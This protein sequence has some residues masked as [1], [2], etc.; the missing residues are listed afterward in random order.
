MKN[1]LPVTALLS[2]LCTIAHAQK[3]VYGNEWINLQQAYYKIPIAQKGLYRLTYVDLQRAGLPLT[4]LDPQK[5]QLFHRGTEQ[6]IW[7][8]G[9]AD[10]KFD[11]TDYIEFLGRGNDGVQDSTLYRPASAQPNPYYSLYSDSTAFFL[12]IRSDT[13]TGKRMVRYTDLDGGQV[14]R[15]LRRSRTCGPRNCVIL[16]IRIR[17]VTSTQ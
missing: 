4:S 5:L 2:L 11:A 6:A 7:V 8:E 17:R 10:G 13:R 12:T 1:W 16:M 9:E 3:P 14:Q 15:P